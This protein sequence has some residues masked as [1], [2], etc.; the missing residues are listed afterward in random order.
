MQRGNSSLHYVFDSSEFVGHILECAD[1]EPNLRHIFANLDLNRLRT[2][3]SILAVILLFIGT[4]KN[5][6]MGHFWPL[7]SDTNPNK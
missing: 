3:I 1:R 5:S 2:V 6:K 4:R 7:I